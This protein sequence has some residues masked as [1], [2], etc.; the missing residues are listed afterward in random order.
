MNWCWSELKALHRKE[1]LMALKKNEK[2]SGII[3]LS[4]LFLGIL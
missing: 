1:S 4:F 2:I 3:L